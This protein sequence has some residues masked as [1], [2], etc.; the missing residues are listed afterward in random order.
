MYD[1]LKPFGI[2]Q[3]VRTGRIS[4]SKDEMQI[5]ALLNEFYQDK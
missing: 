3:F 1:Q 4:V 2:M 5:T